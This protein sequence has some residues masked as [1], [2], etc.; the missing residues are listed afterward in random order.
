MAACFNEDDQIIIERQETDPDLLEEGRESLLELLMT[1]DN[2][3]SVPLPRGV[4]RPSQ[5]P[6]LSFIGPVTYPNGSP[7][8]QSSVHPTAQAPSQ[9]PVQGPAQAPLQT[10]AQVPSQTPVQG[11]AQAPLQTPAQVPSQTPAQTPS[12]IPAQS[13]AQQAPAHPSGQLSAPAPAKIIAQPIPQQRTQPTPQQRTQP[14]VQQAQLPAQTRVNPLISQVPSVLMNFS[15]NGISQILLEVRSHLQS[16]HQ[17]LDQLD[18]L[19]EH[20]AWGSAA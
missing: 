1:M 8:G 19:A 2:D 14:T 15:M 5:Q 16:I 13:P 9:T 3:L 10:P 7:A 6:A 12:Q 18:S 4:E 11:P 20:H 17:K